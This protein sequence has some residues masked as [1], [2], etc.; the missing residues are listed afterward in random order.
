MQQPKKT[1]ELH[2]KQPTMREIIFVTVVWINAPLRGAINAF[3]GLGEWS[4]KKQQATQNIT[5]PTFALRSTLFLRPVFGAK[6]T[7]QIDHVPS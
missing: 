6:K 4:Q 7:C 1:Q 3:L 5:F 2:C